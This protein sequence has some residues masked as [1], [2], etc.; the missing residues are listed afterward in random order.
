MWATLAHALIAPLEQGW[1][2]FLAQKFNRASVGHPLGKGGRRSARLKFE[3]RP[4]WGKKG[5]GISY[6]SR[7]TEKYRP[8]LLLEGCE[9][10]ASFATG[11]N[12]LS[13]MLRCPE[14]SEFVWVVFISPPAGGGCG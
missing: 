2:Q 3:T 6:G 5:P 9:G 14:L 13:L 10:L 7:E 12:H 4:R 8:Y 1:L 11:T